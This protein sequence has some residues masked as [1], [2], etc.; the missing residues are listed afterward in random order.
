MTIADWRTIPGA[1]SVKFLPLMRKMD[2]FCCNSFIL[3]THKYIIV[4][5]PGADLEQ[6]DRL[7]RIVGDLVRE[8]ARP[9][10]VFHTHS[11]RD[12]TKAVSALADMAGA[13]VILF[14]QEEGAK[15]I[16]KGDTETTQY[17]L[18]KEEVPPLKIDIP[19]L[20]REERENPCFKEIALDGFPPIRMT[21]RALSLPEGRLLYT[22][23]LPIS[24]DDSMVI[25][26][27]PGH[28]PDGISIQ[29]GNALFIGDLLLAANPCVAGIHGWNREDLM[30]S[31]ANVIWSL[32]K[33]GITI[34]YAGHGD[35]LASEKT[36]SLLEKSLA[37]TRTQDNV[38]RYDA[39]R[40]EYVSEY[41]SVVLREAADLFTIIAGRLYALCHH[42]EF[43]DED[44][45]A[46]EILA[47]LDLDSIDAFLGEF[48]N[49]VEEVRSRGINALLVPFKAL[50]VTKKIE[51]A[52]NDTALEG[53]ISASLLRR[54]RRLVT[55]FANIILG[56]RREDFTQPENLNS[57]LD[58]MIRELKSKPCDDDAIMDV[59]ED[60]EAFVRLLA[61]RMSRQSLFEKTAIHF[62]PA[63]APPMA[64][65]DKTHI[66]DTMTEMLERLS[67]RGAR[68][69]I[70]RIRQGE[71]AVQI[72]L[73]ARP[74]D[75]RDVFS[76]HRMKYFD[77]VFREYGG[78]FELSAADDESV[79][80]ARLPAA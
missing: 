14:M 60:H 37:E 6:M 1:P 34:C 2:C 65:M 25:Y 28:S 18:F 36:I 32:K 50:V 47:A 40:V 58:E 52:F 64:L 16:E 48:Q 54:T 11:H 5:D 4:L 10:L 44:E 71:G 31:Y 74:C 80:I 75:I 9:V 68:E 70:F 49:Y 35:M 78:S 33:G 23:T 24:E 22:Q 66:A 67:A 8:A 13:R 59:L 51:R 29:V 17:S 19:L 12:H 61:R 53:L 43:L 45:K 41:A 77:M 79:F 76:S 56:L 27:T 15:A 63:P 42:L 55:D 72:F 3:H 46:R 73:S 62:E 26:Y 30:A 57:V 69:I 21:T 20:T 38:A 7:C 39:A